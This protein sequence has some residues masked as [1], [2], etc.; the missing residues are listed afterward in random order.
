[1]LCCVKSVS[2]RTGGEVL[3]GTVRSRP[4]MKTS[5]LSARPARKGKQGTC[6]E[7]EKSEKRV[8]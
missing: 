4:I 8:L 1:M 3:F 6:E 5:S 2:L 7:S